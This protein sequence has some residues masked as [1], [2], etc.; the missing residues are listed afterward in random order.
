MLSILRRNFF[1]VTAILFQITCRGGV[2][3]LQVALNS[4]RQ[5]YMDWQRLD[6]EL[7]SMA[8]EQADYELLEFRQFVDE[9]KNLVISFCDKVV[10]LGGDPSTVNVDCAQLT[11]GGQPTI[12]IIS[13]LPVVSSEHDP[14]VILET[15][16]KAKLAEV[17]QILLKN[18]AILDNEEPPQLPPDPAIY[19]EGETNPTQ[20]GSDRST[21]LSTGSG[22]KYEPGGGPGVKKYDIQEEGEGKRADVSDDDEVARQIREAAEEEIDPELKKKLW[23]DYRKYKAESR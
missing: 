20:Q 5:S 23:E 9:Q 6:A 14:M 10:Q 4:L 11:Q 19:G 17:D 1:I 18:Q 16:H 3:E 12:H 21:N 2:G 8:A 7:Q 15:K 22:T 13:E